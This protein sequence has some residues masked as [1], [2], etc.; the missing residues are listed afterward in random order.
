MA[1]SSVDTH[2]VGSLDPSNFLVDTTMVID[3]CQRMEV[4]RVTLCGEIKGAHS[5]VAMKQIR[6]RG[7][8]AKIV[9]YVQES[10]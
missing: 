5:N 4:E 6:H 8:I 1:V 7:S 3:L 9:V 2:H 10:S